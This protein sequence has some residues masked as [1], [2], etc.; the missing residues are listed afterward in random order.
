MKKEKKK[1]CILCGRESPNPYG[2]CYCSYNMECFQDPKIYKLIK[3]FR[4]KNIIEISY[5]FRK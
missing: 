1:V 4:K 3:K 2:D 5:G